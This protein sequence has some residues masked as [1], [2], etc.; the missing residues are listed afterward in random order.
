MVLSTRHISGLG[1][2]EKRIPRFH[3]T[4]IYPLNPHTFSAKDF[5]VPAM[6]QEGNKTVSVA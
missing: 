3:V 6:L 1:S 4:G 2:E 5:L